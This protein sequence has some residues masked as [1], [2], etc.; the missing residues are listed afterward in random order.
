VSGN[1]AADTIRNFDPLTLPGIVSVTNPFPAADGTDAETNE[2][3]RRLAPQEFRARQFRSVTAADY[4]RAAELLPW[5]S[6]AGTAFRW[7]GSWLTVF[8]TVDPKGTESISVAHHT[9]LI[10]L[11]NRY[12][13][14]GY[15][16]YT[17]APRFASLDLK[18]K[19]CA[20][21]DAFRGD[22]EAAILAVLGTQTSAA[23]GGFFS[24]DKFTFGT[25][26]ER[27]SLEAA[28]Q[29]A[30]GVAG[31][32]CITYRQRGLN[33]T[34]VAMPE[35]VSIGSNQILRVDNDPSR[36]EAGSIKVEVEGGK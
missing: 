20:Q 17:P 32:L 12:R 36:P 27:S 1:V 26:L 22:V 24:P 15:E 19:V 34:Y 14:A 10:N 18:I 23:G 5:V 2:R 11:L 21:R 6:N 8:T 31:V 28:I 9:E 25:P 29:S 16:S 30:Y 33:H 4:E 13:L 35:T 7:T 3:V